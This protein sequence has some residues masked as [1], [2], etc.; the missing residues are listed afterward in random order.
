[1]SSRSGH[2]DAFSMYRLAYAVAHDDF[3]IQDEAITHDDR[4]SYAEVPLATLKAVDFS[5]VDTITIAYGTNDFGEGATNLDNSENRL[6]TS[7]VCGALRYSLD[8]LLTAYPSIEIYVIGLIYRTINGVSSDTYENAKHNTIAQYNAALKAVADEFHVR[9][10]DNNN[11]GFSAYT[12]A[13]YYIDGTH[14]NDAGL[15]VYARHLAKE[16]NR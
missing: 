10:I 7:T 1:M 14:P 3:D 13:T 4:P 2:W 15:L 6:D 11:I 5:K 8:Q 16:L 9:F 12:N